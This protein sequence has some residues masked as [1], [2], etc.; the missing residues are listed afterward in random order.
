LSIH[1]IN[2]LFQN[3]GCNIAMSLVLGL[4]VVAMLGWGPRSCGAQ[5]PEDA[6]KQAAEQPI[7]TVGDLKITHDM[8]QTPREVLTGVD[9]MR[10]EGSQIDGRIQGALALIMAKKAGVDLSD[11][12]VKKVVIRGSIESWKAGLR[13]RPGATE[14]EFE[15]AFKAASGR[16]F[17]D[18]RKELD[19][20]IDEKLKTNEAQASAATILLAD[21]EKSKYIP[22]DQVLKDKSQTNQ[23]KV[24]TVTNKMVGAKDSDPEA[25]TG[26]LKK[27]KAEQILKEIKGG[28]SFEAAMDKYLPAEKGKKPSA[29][30]P[31]DIPAEMVSQ[32]PD[33]GKLKVGESAI[34]F[35]SSIYK[36]TNQK[37]PDNWDKA[38]AA[39]DYAKNEAAKHVMEETAKL[40]TPQ[41]V[42][43]QSE[44]YHI[45]HDYLAI[46]PTEQNRAA[47]LKAI[48]DR[49]LK[50]QGDLMDSK[51]AVAAGKMA[52]TEAT[53]GMKEQDAAKLRADVLAAYTQQFP[54]L[55][56]KIDEA[57]AYITLGDAD[58]TTVT[59]KDA[60]DQSS[61]NTDPEGKTNWDSINKKVARAK[62][63]N[64]LR[65][66]DEKKIADEYAEWQKQYAE[67]QKRI[68][69]QEAQ[70][71]KTEAELS[72][73]DKTPAPGGK[74]PAP[75][76]TTPKSPAAK[77]PVTKT[78]APK[79]PTT[80]AKKP[81]GKP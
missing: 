11:E 54:E 57:D 15:N 21:R 34:V 50:V 9:E 4:S 27:A 71:K 29:A 8:I 74:P 10:D 41:N 62:A 72:K 38:K 59:L 28:L 36:L 1:Q 68:K 69:D 31:S 78:P 22:S 51:P 16:S 19:K 44:G 55:D 49:A 37:M 25:K 80:G 42:K 6:A 2:K 23:Y 39:D 24:I 18:V 67:E 63:K 65:P 3:K 60:A 17:A 75:G 52:L 77:P 26:P 7:V 33:L 32:L 66:E 35:S 46:K 40:D 70:Q 14:Q 73:A 12:N 20:T 5:S 48:I 13:L 81:A 53:L 30:P 61:I 76:A 45:L 47:K 79:G 56:A 58:N 64:L 43:W